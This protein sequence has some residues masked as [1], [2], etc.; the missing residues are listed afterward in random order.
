MPFGTK[1]FLSSHW[2]TLRDVTEASRHHVVL[3]ETWAPPWP[4]RIKR[5]SGWGD[6][7]LKPR[8]AAWWERGTRALFTTLSKEWVLHISTCEPAPL[9]FW[10]T[11]ETK[12]HTCYV[13][14]LPD[15][16]YSCL[17]HCGQG[18]ENKW[19]LTRY[20]TVHSRSLFIHLDL[21][22]SE[23][24]H[25]SLLRL[26]TLI[27]G[28]REKFCCVKFSGLA[29]SKLVLSRGAHGG[30]WW[31]HPES[32]MHGGCVCLVSSLCK[33]AKMVTRRMCKPEWWWPRWLLG[34][35]EKWKHNHSC[36]LFFTMCYQFNKTDKWI[37]NHQ[38]CIEHLVHRLR[39]SLQTCVCWMPLNY[40]TGVMHTRIQQRVG[41]R[42]N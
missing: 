20:A 15:L 38:P 3:E 10:S 21:P 13:V 19:I 24:N 7:L 37:Q 30:S 32:P 36:T 28:E 14:Q 29:P 25:S 12:I 31:T 23:C 8:L 33:K 26:L 40:C 42:Q 39:W 34:E 1:M 9:L 35:K 41:Q 18:T 6:S 16:K 17:Y 22:H 11:I 2:C 5:K 4:M 27:P